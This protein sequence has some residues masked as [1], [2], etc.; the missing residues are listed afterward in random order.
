[1]VWRFILS[2]GIL[3]TARFCSYLFYVT[4]LNPYSLQSF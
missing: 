3:I 2:G 1:M 4:D